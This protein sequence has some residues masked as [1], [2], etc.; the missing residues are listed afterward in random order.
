MA[1]AA[2]PSPPLCELCVLI[3]SLVPGMG[4]GVGNCARSKWAAGFDHMTSPPSHALIGLD[5]L[6]SST[7]SARARFDPPSGTHLAPT[8]PF[9]TYAD[10]HAWSSTKMFGFIL[11]LAV[12]PRAALSR[13]ERS[14][15][16][17]L[18]SLALLL[19]S[20]PG[21]HASEERCQDLDDDRTDSASEGCDW[22]DTNSAS[23]GNND[24][25]DFNLDDDDDLDLDD[26]DAS[27][28]DDLV[29]QREPV[30]WVVERDIET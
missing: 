9:H 12:G 8:H 13:D 2:A 4:A 1:R 10:H 6:E 23:C 20:R 24:D 18:Y 21:A 30:A 27:L 25:D 5:S 15:Q 28:A 26:V 14:R 19:I 3:F 11:G 17:T 16:T 22:Y 7:D 29:L